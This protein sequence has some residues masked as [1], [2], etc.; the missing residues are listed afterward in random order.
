MYYPFAKYFLSFFDIIK[1]RKVLNF[2]KKENGSKISIFLDV[3]AHRGESI[4]IFKKYFELNKIFAFEPSSE[5]FDK[6]KNEIKNIKNLK[7]FN[8]ALGEKSGFIDFKDHYDS[9]SS[10]IVDI[11][12]NS[13]YFKKKN[14]YLNFFSKNKNFYSKSKVKIDR[15]DNILKKENIKNIDLI[16]IDTEGYDFYVIKGLGEMIKNVKYIYFEHHFHNMLNKNYTYF[17]VDKYLRNNNFKKVFKSKM[18][19]RKTLEYI[20]RNNFYLND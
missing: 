7:I 8:I 4:K 5:N 11:N 12:E 14:F 10:T 3:G 16:K 13:N 20:Y 18:F 19:F 17:E 9:Q 1:K 15:M 6:L 2:I